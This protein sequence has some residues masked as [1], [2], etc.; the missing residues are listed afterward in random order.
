[1]KVNR[2]SDISSQWTKKKNQQVINNPKGQIIYILKG[3]FYNH[4]KPLA[5]QPSFYINN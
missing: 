2:G 1:M 5:V 3:V 4:A